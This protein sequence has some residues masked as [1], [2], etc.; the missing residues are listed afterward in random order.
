MGTY[1]SPN[2]NDNIVLQEVQSRDGKV[3]T[4]GN[5]IIIGVQVNFSQM[6]EGR[7]IKDDF[8]QCL[9]NF[10]YHPEKGHLWSSLLR[11]SEEAKAIIEFASRH[12]LGIDEDLKTKLKV[13]SSDPSYFQNLTLQST[14]EMKQTIDHAIHIDLNLA[15][16]E[17]R[18]SQFKQLDKLGLLNNGIDIRADGGVFKIETQQQAKAFMLFAEQYKVEVSAELT[19][20]LSHNLAH[21]SIDESNANITQD[22]GPKNGNSQENTSGSS[23]NLKKE[24]GASGLSNAIEEAVTVGFDA[25][26]GLLGGSIKGVLNQFKSKPTDSIK[27]PSQPDELSNNLPVM[28]SK[29]H[30][31]KRGLLMEAA[32]K[33]LHNLINHAEDLPELIGSV[34]K[35]KGITNQM[36]QDDLTVITGDKA[37]APAFKQHEENGEAL[38]SVIKSLSKLLKG[39]PKSERKEYLEGIES[40]KD[41]VALQKEELTS[42]IKAPALKSYLDST[43]DKV[44]NQLLEA[45]EK[46]KSWIKLDGANKEANSDLS[47]AN[48]SPAPA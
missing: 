2:T 21:N 18:D 39:A 32:E 37:L 22:R 20:A 40:I 33:H 46:L 29:Y 7:L 16:G 13:A 38:E 35:A 1:R 15:D 8:K 11:T 28:N 45:F 10:R 26:G 24:A 34:K 30:E 31:D 12:G 17:S 47:T 4:R 25:V 19:N 44:M 36:I 27:Q 5:G 48:K 23:N 3:E 14:A 43:M 42:D 6:E 41:R 9:S